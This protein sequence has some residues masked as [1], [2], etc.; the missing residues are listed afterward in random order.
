MWS[1]ARM[2]GDKDFVYMK[3]EIERFKKL[4]ALKSVSLNEKKRNAEKKESEE[5][6][7]KRKKELL[8]RSEPKEKV[9]LVT[10]ANVGNPG[11]TIAPPPKPD[12]KAKPPV[13]SSADPATPDEPPVP[14]IDFNLN[15][16]ERIL[17]DMISLRPQASG[18]ASVRR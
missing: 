8:A 17:M 16:T 14:I 4:V 15:E 1:E 3:D 7:A 2:A 5:R 9:Y 12:K 13:D 11:L 6:V 10:L 18:N